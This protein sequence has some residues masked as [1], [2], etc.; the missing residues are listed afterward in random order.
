[1]T[2]QR[3]ALGMQ[4]VANMERITHDRIGDMGL[5][6]ARA[7]AQHLAR[8]QSLAALRKEEVGRGEAAIIIAAGPSIKHRNPAVR[9]KDSGFQGAIIAS[10]SALY[11]CLRNGIVPDLVLTLDPHPVRIV[12]WFGDPNLDQERLAADDYFRRQDMDEAFAD[13]LRVNEEVLGLL[14]RHGKDIRIALSTS[15]SAAV[16]SRVLEIGMSIYWWN[17]M[18]DD[19]DLPDSVTAKLQKEN[20]LPCVNAGGNVGSACWMMA[21]AVLQKKHIALTGMD[22]SYYSDTPYE[23]TQYYKEAV[24]LVGEENLDSIYIHIHNPHL[25]QSFYTDPAYM[26]YRESL[27][28]MVRD[29]DCITYNCTEGGILFDDSLQFIP[30]GQFL[31]EQSQLSSAKLSVSKTHG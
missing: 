24:A 19:P 9:I 28:E 27:L 22:L 26:W 12:R 14:D 16:V 17:P 13:E 30:L 7:N 31:G 25:D 2:E 29:A 4:L 10:D 8:G 11:Y 6:N 20:R 21:S 3:G 5:N 1:M 15:A 18:Y 23:N